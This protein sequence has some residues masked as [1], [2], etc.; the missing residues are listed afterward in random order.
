MAQQNFQAPY[1]ILPKLERQKQG[2]RIKIIEDEV[3]GADQVTIEFIG[4]DLIGCH[5]CIL[6]YRKIIAL[7][8]LITLSRDIQS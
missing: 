2:E 3:R 5:F 6:K 1:M 7:D 8:N 4:N